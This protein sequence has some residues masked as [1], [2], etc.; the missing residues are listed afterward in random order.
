M[1]VT[2]ESR[3]TAYIKTGYLHRRAGKLQTYKHVSYTGEK[4]HCSYINRLDIQ[5]SRDTADI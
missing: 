4:G 5:E 3:D 2:Q 1:L